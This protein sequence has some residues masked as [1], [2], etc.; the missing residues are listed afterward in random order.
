MGKRERDGPKGNE[1]TKDREEKEEQE[2]K[3]S[4]GHAREM[5]ER[6]K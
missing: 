6:G 5:T 2:Q 1:K 3:E 4:K